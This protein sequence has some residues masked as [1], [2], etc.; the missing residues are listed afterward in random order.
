LSERSEALGVG[1]QLFRQHVMWAIYLWGKQP[2]LL[3]MITAYSSIQHTTLTASIHTC[4]AQY[5][6]AISY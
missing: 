3:Q 4:Y 1:F 5:A 2:M 6:C